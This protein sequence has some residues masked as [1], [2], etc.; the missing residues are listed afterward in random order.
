MSEIA[1]S[2]RPAEVRLGESAYSK[3]WLKKG[4]IQKVL[5]LQESTS[6]RFGAIAHRLNLLTEH[7]LA[8]LLAEQ[9]E[10]PAILKEQLIDAGLISDQ[11]AETLFSQFSHEREQRL[12]TAASHVS[13]A[14]D[15]PVASS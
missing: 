1:Q 13:A 6:E 11:E 7:Q 14:A 9:S 2:S 12:E 15:T 4:D 5:H 8:L 3:E 10:C